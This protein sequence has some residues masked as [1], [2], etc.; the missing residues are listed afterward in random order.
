MARALLVLALL[1]LPANHLIAAEAYDEAQ[2]HLNQVLA[3]NA[4]L[5]SL[6]SRLCLFSF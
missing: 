5:I 3:I 4:G 1:L 2:S 6:I